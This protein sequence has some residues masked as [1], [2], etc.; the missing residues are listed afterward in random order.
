MRPAMVALRPSKRRD[1]MGT[2]VGT[3][4]SQE[5]PGE[6]RRSQEKPGEGRRS[7]EISR[8]EDV[9]RIAQRQLMRLTLGGG[10]PAAKRRKAARRS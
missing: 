6:A 4:R 7:Q 9:K 10:G 3:K 5:K 2:S 1:V 8:S